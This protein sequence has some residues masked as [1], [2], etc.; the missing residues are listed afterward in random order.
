MFDKLE[1]VVRNKVCVGRQCDTLQRP[2]GV[3]RIQFTK[4][5]QQKCIALLSRISVILSRD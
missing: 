5:G 1:E 3:L 4:F 2:S